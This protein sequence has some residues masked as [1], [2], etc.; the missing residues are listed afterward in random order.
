MKKIFFVIFTVILIVL[1]TFLFR[2]YN[3]TSTQQPKEQAWRTLETGQG[4]KVASTTD[5]NSYLYSFDE[6]EKSELQK[7]NFDK[8]YTMIMTVS[9]EGVV[10]DEERHLAESYSN[11]MPTSI[12]LSPFEFFEKND[13]GKL[14]PKDTDKFYSPGKYT[15]TIK[16]YND[17]NVYTQYVEL[18]QALSTLQAPVLELHKSVLVTG[19][20]IQRECAKNADCTASCPNCTTGKSYCETFQTF[21]CIQCFR[22][23]ECKDGF[24][25]TNNTCVPK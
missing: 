20:P 1:G 5:E 6:K 19:K 3:N 9:K 24:T 7:A 11:G 4:L 22:N 23:Y 10:S 18:D 14:L 16:I 2:Q 25:C 21:S 17:V 15:Y 13:E 12:N 8:G